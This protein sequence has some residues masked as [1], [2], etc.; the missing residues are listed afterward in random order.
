M[1]LPVDLIIYDFD[2]VMTDNRVLVFEDG[3]E[4]V[5]VN[6]SDGLAIKTIK[7]MGIAQMIISTET[8]AV[9][10]AR[11]RKLKIPLVQSVD[12]K[13]KVVEDY[14]KKNNIDRRRVAF[15]GNDIND[16]EVMESVGW[17]VASSD[18][19]KEIIKIAK[20]LL[21]SKGGCGVV[22]EFLDRLR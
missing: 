15:L 17:P 10:K 1:K 21:K 7:E 20:V 4:A 9:V 16:K 22:R 3:K 12:N 6:R 8:N 2:G 19:H 13:R 5:F 11:A 18:A 14:L